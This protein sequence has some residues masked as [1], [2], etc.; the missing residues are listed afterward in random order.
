M[1]KA[2]AML[3]AIFM[4][5][6]AAAAPAHAHS[7]A[8]PNSITDKFRKNNEHCELS[9]PAKFEAVEGYSECRSPATN[10][11]GSHDDCPECRTCHHVAAVI[12][13]GPS[14]LILQQLSRLNFSV[15]FKV[16]LAV[17]DGPIEP[18]RA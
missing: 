14:R 12:P 6:A 2:I 9:A 1:R 4:I 11:H 8:Y 16:I 15:R 10:H 7:D 18:P 17:I 3:M 5:S 13:S